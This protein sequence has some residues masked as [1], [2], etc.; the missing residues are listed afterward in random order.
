MGEKEFNFPGLELQFGPDHPA[1]G[2]HFPGAPIVPG[3]V[4][5]DNIIRALEENSQMN[6]FVDGL[7]FV[8]F[9]APLL[10]DQLLKLQFSFLSLHRIQFFGNAQGSKVIFGV[11]LVQSH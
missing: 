4:I 11:L 3:V 5:L 8:K 7:E 1:F 6:L 2:G 10:P 9:F